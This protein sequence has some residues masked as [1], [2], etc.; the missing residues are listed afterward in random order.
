MTIVDYYVDA[1]KKFFDFKGCADRPAY[2]WFSLANLIVY[3]VLGL[4][5]EYLAL[6]YL[7]AVLIPSLAITVRRI[8]DT[9]HSPWHI[10]WCLLPLFGGLIILVFTL[11]P[12]KGRK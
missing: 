11:L 10:L 6:G 2:W 12:T 7:L 1:L 3:F 5:S 9:G 4:A 8:R